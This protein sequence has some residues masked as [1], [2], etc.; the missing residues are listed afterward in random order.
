MAGGKVIGKNEFRRFHI[1]FEVIII[2]YYNHGNQAFFKKREKIILKRTNPNP[3]M[4][5]LSYEVSTYVFSSLSTL[6]R[7]AI[8]IH[9]VRRICILIVRCFVFSDHFFHSYN[10]NI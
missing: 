4:F 1:H 6:Q 7:F 10:L 3:Q 9:V 8:A 2:S 5:F